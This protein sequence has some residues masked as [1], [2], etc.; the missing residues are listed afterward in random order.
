MQLLS[1]NIPNE[2]TDLA[3]DALA[4]S[5]LYTRGHNRSGGSGQCDTHCLENLLAYVDKKTKI[6]L[7]AC[8][9]FVSKLDM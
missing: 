8:E 1:Q 4:S 6:S 3:N 7:S 2:T 9:S 5:F